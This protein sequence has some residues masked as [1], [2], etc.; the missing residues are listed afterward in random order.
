[1]YHRLYHLS[2]PREDSLSS[3]FDY[4]FE[5]LDVEEATDAGTDDEAAAN[6]AARE[7]SPSRGPGAPVRVGFAAFVLGAL[8]AVAV[9]AVLL[10]QRPSGPADPVEVPLEQTP[11]STVAEV[12][13]APAPSDTTVTAPVEVP[14][15]VDSVLPRA[16]APA[17]EPTRASPPRQSERAPAIS[18]TTRAPISVAPETRVPFPNQAP[19]GGG[20]QNGGLL[21]GLL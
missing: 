7:A 12:P 18:P 3:R 15:T 11:L 4:L 9:I 13:A 20:G 14:E 16:S 17:P 2:M 1:M 10:L 8:G 6:G 21:G 19:R 5:P